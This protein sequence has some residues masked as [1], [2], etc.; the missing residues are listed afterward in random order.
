MNGHRKCLYTHIILFHQKKEGNIAICN[1][2][3]EL[4]RHYTKWNKPNRERHIPYGTTYKWNL[5]QHINKKA[6]LIETESKMVFSR[7]WGNGERLV[8]ECKLSVFRWITSQDLMYSM[9]TTGN[10]MEL[11]T[12]NLPGVYIKHFHP[13]PWQS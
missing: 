3:D 10:N 8:K 9:A 11:Y 2:M 6:N 1:N 13:F 7:A 12:W 5:K 4:E